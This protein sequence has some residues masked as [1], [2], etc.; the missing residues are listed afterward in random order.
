MANEGYG[1]A[2][3]PDYLLTPA[4]KKNILNLFELNTYKIIAAWPLYKELDKKS[5]LFIEQFN[6]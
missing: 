6:H 2:L 1:I 4:E 3:L 5:H